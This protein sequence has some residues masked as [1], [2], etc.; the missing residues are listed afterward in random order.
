MALGKGREVK[1]ACICTVD[2]PITDELN[3]YTL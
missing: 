1:K 3:L 2:G